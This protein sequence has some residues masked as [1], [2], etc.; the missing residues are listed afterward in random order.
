MIRRVAVTGVAGFIGSHLAVRLA[1]AGLEVQGCDWAR[2]DGTTPLDPDPTSPASCLRRERLQEVRLAGVATSVL[3]IARDGALADW[4]GDRPTD[5]MI[6]LAAQAGVR[7]SLEAPLDFV[8][9]NLVGFAQVLEACR[10]RAVPHLLYA[11][12][13]SVYGAR[14]AGLFAEDDRVD[15]PESFYAA[16][17]IA[18]EMMASAYA[19]QYGLC[20]TGMRFFTVFGPRGRPDM[21]PYLFAERLWLGQALT[22]FAGGELL[23]D[24]TFVDDTVAAIEALSRTASSRQAHTVCNVGHSRP[25]RVIDFVQ[26]LARAMGRTP[27]LQSL[28]MQKADVPMTCADDSR[29][30][31]WVGEWPDTPLET[32]L[33]RFADWFLRWYPGWRTAAGA[34]AGPTVQAGSGLTQ[35]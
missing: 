6:H 16:T 3:D 29:L 22:L 7:R 18:N 26:T 27:S 9:P 1:R 24:F 13:S 12:S 33:R 23:R 21:A 28:P 8:A 25:V 15:R 19:A 17:K 2:E 10:Q 34:V 5:R 20:A 35:P 32:G 11:S 30:R 4:L 14:T 31:H